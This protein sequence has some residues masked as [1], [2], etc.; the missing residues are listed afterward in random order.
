[1]CGVDFQGIQLVIVLGCQIAT[2][3]TGLHVNRV[4]HSQHTHTITHVPFLLLPDYIIVKP[5]SFVSD[6]M[7][8]RGS[9][10]SLVSSKRKGIMGYIEEGRR[11]NTPSCTCFS[12]HP[13]RKDKVVDSNLVSVYAIWC[14]TE[15]V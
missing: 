13:K 10:K 14:H 2:R 12:I 15:R 3:R 11:H 9:E 6:L 5:P 4:A 1:M 7:V 8:T